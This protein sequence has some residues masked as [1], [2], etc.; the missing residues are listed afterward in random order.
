MSDA[1]RKHPK[2][3][4]VLFLTEMWERFGFY[5]LAGLFVLYMTQDL[6]VSD[7]QAALLFGAFAS[8]LYV[9]P[10]I[11]GYLADR[12]MGFR[13]AIMLGAL[14]MGAGYLS[15]AIGEASLIPVSLAVLIVGNGFFKPNTSALLGHLYDDDDPRLESGFTIFYLGINVGSFTAF[16]ISGWIA[17]QVGYNWAFG[18]AGIGKLI[19]FLTF[20]IG[21]RWLND[22]GHAPHP[23]VLKERH[24]GIPVFGLIAIGSVAV[25]AIAA[26][27]MIH[28]VV[29]GEVLAVVGVLAFAYFIYAGWREGRSVRRRIIALAIL[30]AFSIVFWAVYM[31][32][33]SSF[34][35]FVERS[36]DRT[37]FD[38]TIPPTAFQ[39]F[40]PLFILSM[41]MPL[42]ALWIWLGKRGS[43]PSIPL[44]FV[45]GLIFLGAAFFVLVLGI[46]TSTDRVPWEWL[47]LFFF[48]FTA[49][50]M[51]L[52]P[53]GLAM[54]SDL[55]P[56]NLTGLAMGIWYLATAGGLYMSGVLADFAA[57]PKDT[58]SAATNDIY[59]SGFST[60]GWIGVASG[61]L[62]LVMVPWLKRL[63]GK[64]VKAF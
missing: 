37:M 58:K 29:A 15:L 17:T 23:E 34:M 8:I 19:A 50:E 61:L 22:V 2:G 43:N 27:F 40:N 18:L 25:A 3:L 21:Q 64:N 35:L 7:A 52:S 62:L 53:V 38:L 44:K 48:L 46:A 26:F 4:Y 56:R 20:V 31:E 5:T 41:G 24:F 12:L 10:L 36:V 28:D 51:V 63:I 60:Y 9:T 13:S 42:A 14:I 45:M 32:V 16:L 39:A 47:I 11:G 57:V 33:D 6:K 49:G 59:A 1:K 54:V 55:A 30:S